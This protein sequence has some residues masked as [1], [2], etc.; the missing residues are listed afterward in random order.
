MF[1]SCRTSVPHDDDAHDL[2]RRGR[3]ARV[4]PPPDGPARGGVARHAAPPRRPGLR[5]RAVRRDA[6]VHPRTAGTTSRRPRSPT[7]RS[8]PSSTALAWTD[9]EI[10]WL[11]S[12]VPTAMI[13]DDHDLRDDCNT[14]M[15]W[16][17]QMD[18]GRVVAA[19]GD[20]RPRRLLGLPA[21]GQPVAAR[22]LVGRAARQAAH[23]GG[24]RGRGPSTRSRK[25][26]DDDPADNRWSYSRDLGDTRLI[27]LDS[28]CARQLDP[29]TTGGCS[30][31]SSG[32]GST[33]RSSGARDRLL[34]GSS[35]PFL[36][37]SGIHDVESWNEAL[38]AGGAWGT[39]G[40]P[41]VGEDPPG[42][43]PGAL[44]GLPPVVRGARQVLVDVAA[45][46]RGRAR[47][48]RAALRRR[49]LLLPWRK[50]P[51]TW[52]PI[53]QVVCSPIRNPLSRTLRLANVIARSASP[54]WSAACSSDG[55]AA[56]ASVQWRITNGP[57]FPNAV[58]TLCLD[59]PG[60]S[61]G[62]RRRHERL[63]DHH[64]GA[65]GGLR[66]EPG[67]RDTPSAAVCDRRVPMPFRPRQAAAPAGAG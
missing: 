13:F 5:R 51:P 26:A 66:Q 4:R 54:P 28:R 52:A 46:R 34:I 11:L 16:R 36:L 29:G 62:H 49:A 35:V 42:R 67:D 65:Q 25:H 45:G 58:A 64:G 55:Q 22:A 57:W 2:A 17:E 32:P 47:H 39:T 53:Y 30:T 21:P 3:A 48:D 50:A 63:G 8:T 37:P 56:Q 23:G 41:L 14:S 18:E 19:P 24:R 6:G 60:R 1:G 31:R 59:S 44:G 43:R 38:C 10:R 40:R 12:T 15:S 61:L 33:R 27:M 9:P 20:L 7:S